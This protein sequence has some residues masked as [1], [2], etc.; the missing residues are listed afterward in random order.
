MVDG[1]ALHDAVATKAKLGMKSLYATWRK[2]KRIDAFV[3]AW[4][5]SSLDFKHCL[6]TDNEIVVKLPKSRKAWVPVFA[7][8]LKS[9]EPFA[10]LVCSQKEREVLLIVESEY[11]TT[12]W[13]LPI[14][15]HGPDLTLGEPTTAIDVDTLGILW[16]QSN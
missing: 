9:V 11:G 10:I 2:K 16:K 1:R 12:S 14:E 3:I 6:P 7:E 13:H 4:P 15:Q 8:L 5:L